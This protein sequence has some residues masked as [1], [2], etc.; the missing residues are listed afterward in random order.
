MTIAAILLGLVVL[1][2]AVLCGRPLGHYMADVLEGKSVLATRLGA[3]IETAFYRFAGIDP[4]RETGWKQYAIGVLL[5]SV[6]GTLMV[7]S[8]Q[9][10]QAW[11][12]LNPEHLA[13]VTP[14]SSF[15]TAVSF[16]TNTNW[17][18]YSGESTMLVYGL[19]GIIVPF[20]GIK[21]VDV[22]LGLLG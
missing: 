7:Y 4:T 5:F 21:L 11:L 9:R 10:L 16:V 2:L 1:G 15:N 13:N 19:G 18:G 20:V 14:D 17:Q 3:K 6:V 8:L 12:P 22:V